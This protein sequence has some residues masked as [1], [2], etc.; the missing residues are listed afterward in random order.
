MKKNIVLP[1]LFNHIVIFHCNSV[2]WRLCSWRLSGSHVFVIVSLCTASGCGNATTNYGKSQ[3]ACVSNDT[4]IS[5][6]NSP[7]FSGYCKIYHLID[8]NT[9]FPILFSVFNNMQR[10][11]ASWSGLKSI[12][13][14]TTLWIVRHENASSQ[15]HWG[16]A[17]QFGGCPHG[18]CCI[19]R[20][21]TNQYILLGKN[22]K[23][24]I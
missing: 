4:V 2:M 20:H 6:K 14:S 18:N 16:C 5:M 22:T 13:N 7:S 8:W 11:N 19:S 12:G 15:R 1:S 23:N 10:S 3:K 24:F 17:T 9:F 21:H